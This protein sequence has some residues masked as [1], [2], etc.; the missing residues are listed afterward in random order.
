MESLDSSSK[1]C[2]GSV[3]DGAS[4]YPAQQKVVPSR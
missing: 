3:D 4:R 1:N 2:R